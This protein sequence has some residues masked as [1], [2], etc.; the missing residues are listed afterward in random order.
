MSWPRR[1]IKPPSM[2]TYCVPGAVLVCPMFLLNLLLFP[3]H[4]KETGSER[5]SALLRTI[6]AN[7]SSLPTQHRLPTGCP[8]AL[9][10]Q[11][12]G[13][14][15]NKKSPCCVV[16]LQLGATYRKGFLHSFHR[17][18][19]NSVPGATLSRVVPVN[20]EGMCMLWG[21]YTRC[22]LRVSR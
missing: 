22:R 4:S 8:P 17:D 12:A 10:T 5:G 9:A 7:S 19:A 20:K 16:R 14:G 13:E 3:L 6:W 2:A 11:P 21:V 15:E 1:I 18:G